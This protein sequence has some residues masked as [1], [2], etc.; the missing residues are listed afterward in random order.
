MTECTE[1]ARVLQLRFSSDCE[2]HCRLEIPCDSQRTLPYCFRVWDRFR[3]VLL[4]CSEFT[5]IVIHYSNYSKSL[6]NV[7]I[8]YTFSSESLFIVSSLRIVTSLRVLFWYVGLPWVSGTSQ[9]KK[10]CNLKVWI[11]FASDCDLTLRIPSEN[12][13]LSAEFPCNLA[14]AMENHCNCDLRFW[15]AQVKQY[16]DMESGASQGIYKL[17]HVKIAAKEYH[18]AKE[19]Y[20]HTCCSGIVLSKFFWGGGFIS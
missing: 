18:L 19:H 11:A 2:F 9:T 7:V 20:I 13:A 10:R 4:C 8:H 3:S 12:R 14:L 6:P 5:T 1:T 17:W 15:C 16:Q